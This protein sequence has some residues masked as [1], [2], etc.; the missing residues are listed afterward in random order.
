MLFPVTDHLGERGA[1][2]DRVDPDTFLHERGREVVPGEHLEVG[3]D[4]ERGGG[5]VTVHCD[6]V[7]TADHDQQ[8]IIYT[9]DPASSSE[10]AL[11]LLAVVGTQMIDTIARR[12]GSRRQPGPG[13]GGTRM[14]LLHLP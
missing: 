14:L 9:A 10:Q 1:G 13:S 5:P 4:H 8:V 3:G 11:R 7:D 12:S 6:A 2:R